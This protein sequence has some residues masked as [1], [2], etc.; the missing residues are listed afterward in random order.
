MP[1]GIPGKQADEVRGAGAHG[2]AYPASRRQGESGARI[3]HSNVGEAGAGLRGP[4][5]VEQEVRGHDGQEDE[6]HLRHHR[7]GQPHGD[8]QVDGR[9]GGSVHRLEKGSL[10]PP[11]PEI[12]RTGSAFHS[13]HRRLSR[14]PGGSA[15]PAGPPRKWADSQLCIRFQAVQ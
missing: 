9:S 11:C 14:S 4:V 15:L 2:R 6:A 13:V 3:S 10:L 8:L 7:G 12:A 5:L 1:V